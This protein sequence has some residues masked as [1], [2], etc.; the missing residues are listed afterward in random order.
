M[1]RFACT[2]ALLVL[3]L[4]AAR[5]AQGQFFLGG[6]AAWT[7]YQDGGLGGGARLGLDL[8]VLPVDILGVAEFFSPSCEPGRD[9]CSFWGATLDAN[10]RLPIPLVRPYLTGGL[11][12]RSADLSSDEGKVD[13]TGFAVGGGL[14]VALVIRIFA[15]YRYEFFENEK[16]ALEGS[17]VRLGINFNL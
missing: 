16:R 12:F 9:G 15:D 2:A 10:V 13:G 14:D 6:H 17:V 7:S 1:I 5:P 3:A 11:S 4:G 8:P